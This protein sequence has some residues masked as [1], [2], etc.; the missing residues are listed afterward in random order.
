M[1]EVLVLTGLRYGELIA[2]TYDSEGYIDINGTIDFRSQEYSKPVKTSPKTNAAYRKIKLPKRAV[3]LFDEVIEENKFLKLL[4]TYEEHSYIFTNK[5]GLPIDYR[6]FQPSLKRAAKKAGIDRT[7]SSHYLRH[8][9][10]SMLVEMNVP[11]KAIMDRVD[12]KDS[13]VTQEI[14]A[15]VTN[16]LQLKVDDQINEIEI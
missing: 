10:I 14:Y 13:S 7:V 1:V 5:K 3:E 15:H 11:I 4:D 16:K 2:L 8:T 12:H 6:T 9:H